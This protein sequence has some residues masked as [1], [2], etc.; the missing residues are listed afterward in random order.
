MRRKRCFNCD[1]LSYEENDVYDFKDNNAYKYYTE[2]KYKG[3]LNIMDYLDKST[4]V[5]YCDSCF[6]DV[7]H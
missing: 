7:E 1:K 3:N 5:N 6:D 2:N 4:K